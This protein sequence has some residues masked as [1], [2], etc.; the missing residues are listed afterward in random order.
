MRLFEKSLNTND[1]MITKK[2][3]RWADEIGDKTFFYYGE[4]GQHFSFKRFN[5]MANS[6]AHYL[7]NKGVKKGDHISVF[8]MNPLVTTLSMFGIWKAGAIFS[9]INFNYKGSLLSYQ[10]ND[11]Q[12]VWLITERRMIP[13]LN[14]VVKDLPTL[15]AL[16]HD[17]K[18]DEH[19]YSADVLDVK[20]DHFNV[21]DFNDTLEGPKENPN[22]LL[23][24]WDTANII[25]TSGT[26]GPAKGVR[27]SYRWIHAY[28]YYLQK[29]TSQEDV[30]YNDLPMYHVGGAFALLARAAFVGSTVAVWDKFSPTDF[31]NRIE[32]S[33][34]STAILLDVMIPWLMKAPKTSTDHNNSLSKVY[35]QPLPQYHHDVAV[36]FGFDF[37]FSGFGQTEAGNAFVSVINELNGVN[38]TPQ[39]LYKGYS[40]RETL[41]IAKEL[42]VEIKEGKEPLEKGFMG[43]PSSFLEATILNDRDEECLAGEVG[44]LAVRP[45]YPNLLLD[46]YYNKPEA[47]I[48]ASTN[49]WFHTGDAAYKDEEGVFY[50]VDRMGDVIRKKGENVSSYQVEDMLSDHESVNVSAVF[51]IPANEGDEDDIVACVTLKEGEDITEVELEGWI[52]KRIPKFMQPSI[53]R[54]VTHIPRTATNKIEKFKLKN[55]IVSELESMKWERLN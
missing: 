48:K 46:G 15:N 16:I 34:A 50:F 9:P 10:I 3:E 13:R 18:P 47:T 22:V 20:P 11:T 5:E 26:T 41:S 8:L 38:G 40:Y 32:K 43:K 33:G 55:N 39:E 12:P 54:I 44:Q 35:M 52:K 19:D 14:E 37:V 42:E 27:Q 24:Y 25:Y 31:W 21:F 17:P 6:I 2:L 7:Q 30:V 1:E 36:R 28:T 45:K 23:N 49:Y 53:V 4:E 51:P 29:F